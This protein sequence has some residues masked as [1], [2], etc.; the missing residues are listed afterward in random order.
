MTTDTLLRL[1]RIR[2]VLAF[3]WIMRDTGYRK[4]FT[5]RESKLDSESQ[6]QEVI[7]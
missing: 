6:Q 2:R 4:G 1:H 7:I 3:E 5:A